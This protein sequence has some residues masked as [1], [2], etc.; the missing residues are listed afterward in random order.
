MTESFAD[1]LLSTYIHRSFLE[2]DKVKEQLVARLSPLATMRLQMKLSAHYGSQFGY[3]FEDSCPK[4]GW[5]SCSA[6]FHSG[7]TVE[8]RQ[9]NAGQAFGQCLLC[10]DQAKFVQVG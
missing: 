8:K 10:G 1:F 2:D 4:S 7:R 5:Y 9:F 6:C 3:D